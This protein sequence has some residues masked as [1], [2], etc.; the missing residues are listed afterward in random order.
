MLASTYERTAL[1]MVSDYAR[2][3]D[4][5]FAPA[6]FL[7]PEII[8]LATLTCSIALNFAV[9]CLFV[10]GCVWLCLRAMGARSDVSPNMTRKAQTVLL[11]IILGPWLVFTASTF[12]IGGCD[13]GHNNFS[14]GLQPVTEWNY[15]GMVLFLMLSAIGVFWSRNM[16]RFR[17]G[18]T[19]LTLIRVAWGLA[20][21]AVAAVAV[22]IELP[23]SWIPYCILALILCVQVIIMSVLNSGLAKEPLP[24]RVARV[25]RPD[26]ICLARG[27][28]VLYLVLLLGQLPFRITVGNI[29]QEINHNQ[30]HWLMANT[31]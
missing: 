27:L 16:A 18:G 17:A 26:F 21:V 4:G 29:L 2:M 30:V 13:W 24:V 8:L 22:T 10:S 28:L 11:L 20:L 6:C 7:W 9:V 25:I 23:D 15:L 14:I 12:A 31:K 3:R 5:R 1:R 19:I